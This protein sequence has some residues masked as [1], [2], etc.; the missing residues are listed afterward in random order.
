MMAKASSEY[1]DI[2]LLGKTGQGKS[3]LGNKLLGIPSDPREQCEVSI[4][5]Y[6]SS[7]S[8]LND[9]S[10]KRF[11]QADELDPSE[12]MESVTDECQILGTERAIAIPGEGRKKLRVV[13]VP[14]FADSGKL[15]KKTGKKLGIYNGN[16]QIIRWIVRLQAELKLNIRRIVYFLPTRNALEKT[17]KVLQEEL[18]V[19]YHYFGTQIFQCMVLAGTNPP[20]AKFQTRGMEWDED[21]RVQ[22]QRVFKKTLDIVTH[23]EQL[24]CPP[25]VYVSHFCKGSE[26]LN[27]ILTASVPYDC[28]LQLHIQEDVCARCAVKIQYAV[29]GTGKVEVGVVDDEG[30][31]PYERSRCHPFFKRKYTRAQKIIGGLA[32]VATL[33]LPHAIGVGKW[34][35][36][37]NS[38]EVCAS[39][40][41]SPGAPGCLNVRQY[42]A[43]KAADEEEE[44]NHTNKL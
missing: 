36:F 7:L 44:V 26:V 43:I 22:T 23:D 33:G 6:E 42:C 9:S 39:C 32:H 12:R 28:G 11:R 5:Q 25:L 19:M 24:Q 29:A 2:V 38:D 10:E 41:R 8:L 21:E 1:Y 3:T 37:T 4:V 31:M 34:P 40:K 35:G 30:Y 14:G 27:D 18:K 17:D 15:A 16:L 13:D 20:K